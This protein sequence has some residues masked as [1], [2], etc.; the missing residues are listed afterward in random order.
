MVFSTYVEVIPLCGQSS[1][2]PLGIL[3]V[4]GGDPSSNTLVDLT[5]W[6]SPRM[7]RWSLLAQLLGSLSNCIL[8]VCGGDP[9]TKK[10]ARYTR[11][12]SPRMWRWSPLGW[13]CT[14][15]KLVFSTYVEVI[16]V[17][18]SKIKLP[19]GILHVCGGDP[20]GAIPTKN[21]GLYSPRMW[22]WSYRGRYLLVHKYVFSTYVEVIL[23]K[24][25]RRFRAD[26]ILHVCGGDP[27]FQ[28]LK[29]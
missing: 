8:H 19:P 5:N 17:H 29:L 27:M 15:T 2:T 7:W 4:C 22:R 20:A 25:H 6:Y 13:L 3:H 11:E 18:W 28:L 23:K 21:G 16:L 24:L 14:T 10:M 1:I 9:S 12:Y 26:C